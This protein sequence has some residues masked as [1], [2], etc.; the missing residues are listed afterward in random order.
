[1][2]NRELGFPAD[3]SGLPVADN[4][5]S[6]HKLINLQAIDPRPSDHQPPNRES[7]NRTCPKGHSTDRHSAH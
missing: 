4:Q 1:L 2:R 7:A 3:T 6:D 5:L